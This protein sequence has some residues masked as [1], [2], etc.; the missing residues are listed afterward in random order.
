MKK[1]FKAMCAVAVAAAFTGCS[2]INTAAGPGSIY[3]DVQQGQAVTSNALGTKVGTSEA[4]NILGIVVVGDA[5]I[6][7]TAKAAGITKISH[8]DNKK[9]SI[10]GVYSTHTTI[11]YGE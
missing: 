4:K 2:M 8:V 7:A 11:V 10:L 5:S 9:M 3:T 1:I 6:Q